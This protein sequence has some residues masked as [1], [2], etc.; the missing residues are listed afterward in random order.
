[1]IVYVGEYLE[2]E[3]Q[4][5]SEREKVFKSQTI[6]VWQGI[7]ICSRLTLFMLVALC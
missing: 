3:W 5:V 6:C 1:M 2:L 4:S 7:D